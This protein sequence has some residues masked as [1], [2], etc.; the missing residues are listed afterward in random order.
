LRVRAR[1]FHRKL[2]PPCVPRLPK[3]GRPEKARNCVRDDTL[4]FVSQKCGG[5]PW[6]NAVVLA[7][8]LSRPFGLRSESAA[9]GAEAPRLPGF[10][11][12]R[13]PCLCGISVYEMVCGDEWFAGRSTSPRFG[14]AANTNCNSGGVNVEFRVTSGRPGRTAWTR[15]RLL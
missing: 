13:R 5:L 7:Q 15:L 2:I 11:E 14:E 1:R 8:K 10:T 9:S 4:F 12:G 3:C 6:R